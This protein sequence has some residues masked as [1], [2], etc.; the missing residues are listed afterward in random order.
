MKS[1]KVC[2]TTKSTLASLLYKG[3]AT[4]Q[5]TEKWSIVTGFAVICVPPRV[6]SLLTQQHW[7]SRETF[8]S[9]KIIVIRQTRTKK[10]IKFLSE[11]QETTK[12]RCVLFVCYLNYLPTLGQ[13]AHTLHSSQVVENVITVFTK[14]FTCVT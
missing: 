3:L 8:T 7:F 1:S 5:T 4:K 10:I 9:K 2:I 14:T 6:T 13:N 11:L 12:L